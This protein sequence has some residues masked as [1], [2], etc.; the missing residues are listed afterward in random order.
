V[1]GYAAHFCLGAPLARIQIESAVRALLARYGRFRVAE[2]V[3]GD[4]ILMRGP[5]RLTILRAP[6]V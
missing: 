1:F 2:V 3:R 6:E 4:S 5:T